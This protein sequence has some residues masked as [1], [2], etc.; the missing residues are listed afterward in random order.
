MRA[1]TRRRSG[2]PALTALGVPLL[3]DELL[4]CLF[5]WPDGRGLILIGAIRVA[6]P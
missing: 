1:R 2:H 5:A 4:T 3:I 6:I